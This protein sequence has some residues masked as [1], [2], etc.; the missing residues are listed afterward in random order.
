M[1]INFKPRPDCQ[2]AGL[3]QIYDRY[4]RQLTMG[5]FVEVG[6]FDGVSYSNTVFLAECGWTG[7]YIEAHPQFAKVCAEKHKNHPN[8]KVLPNAVGNREG[9]VKLYEI[10]ECS[11]IRWDKSAVDWGGKQE[12]FVMADM[13]TLNTILEEEK[14]E[15]GFELLVIDVEQAELDVL[16]GFNLKHWVP[17][18]VIV[19]THEQDPAPERNWKAKPI[20]K[21]F[22][23]AGYSVIHTDHINTIFVPSTRKKVKPGTTKTIVTIGTG[24][25]QV[26]N[27]EGQI[28]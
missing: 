18:M 27:V 11:T 2:I 3:G 19:E 6:A 20:R 24:G 16:A 13:K 9:Q 14:W 8:V 5:R 28:K 21:H 7:L 10:G 15:P 23:Q 12:R 1:P 25:K 22:I 26:W 17:Q 4:F